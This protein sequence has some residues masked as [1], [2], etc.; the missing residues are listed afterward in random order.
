MTD[1]FDDQLMTRDEW[2]RSENAK[3]RKIRQEMRSGQ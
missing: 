1:E 3:I 2:V